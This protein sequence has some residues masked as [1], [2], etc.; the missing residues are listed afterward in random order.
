MDAG[1]SQ[2]TAG[3]SQA[4]R[5]ESDPRLELIYQEAVRGLSH[6]Q[7]VVESLNTRAG[8]LIFATAFATS[9][10]GVKALADGLS[11]WDWVA[12]MLL[13]GIGALTVFMLWPYD[14][15][16]FRFDPEELLQRYVASA[17]ATRLSDMHRELALRI[18]TDMTANW[19]IIQRVRIALQI[20]LILL[21]LEILAWLVSIAS[22]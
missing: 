21:L 12:V 6:Q 7:G 14:R 3:D 11:V 19:Q 22:R 9:L 17:P 8:N 1:D 13:F 15:Y 16:T 20:A 18:K 5:N 2:L 4:A 10:L